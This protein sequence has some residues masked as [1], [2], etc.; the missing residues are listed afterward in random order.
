M[1][2]RGAPW[3]LEPGSHTTRSKLKATFGGGIQG[4]VVISTSSSQLMIFSDPAAGARLGYVFDGWVPEDNKTYLYTGSG[5]HGDQRIDRGANIAIRDHHAQGRTLRL[6]VADGKVS[7]TNT[8]RQM[9]VGAFELDSVNPYTFQDGLDVQGDPRRLVIFRLHPIGQVLRREIDQAPLP[10]VSS[11]TDSTLVEPDTESSDPFVVVIEG[12]TRTANRVEAALVARYR[13]HLSSQQH[14]LKRNRVR[15]AGELHFLR[16]DLYDVTAR[17]LYEAKG[18]ATRDVVR[19]AIGQLLDYRR[20]ISPPPIA[21]TV[22]L[23]SRPQADLIA[24]L[25]ELG[26]GC[27]CE[28]V[29]GT[30]ER[31]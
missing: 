23:P 22:L 18:T 24:L 13:A 14:V 4:G 1:S 11:S 6:F 7:G 15:P 26:L 25:A 20:Y 12:E 3:T 10:D 28:K 2:P 19:H 16:T 17:E 8:V 29:D 30:W 21:C 9:Y 27:V 5:R 31:L